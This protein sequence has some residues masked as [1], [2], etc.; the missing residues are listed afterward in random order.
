M[1]TLIFIVM[2]FALQIFY[3]LVGRRSASKVESNEEYFLAG[4]SV[5]FFPLMMTF[6]AT[7]VGGGMM[8]GSTEEAYKWGWSVVFYPLGAALGLIALG[9]GLGRKLSQFNVSTIAEILEVV[10]KSSF[11]KRFASVLSMASLFLILMAQMVASAHFLNSMGFTSTP[12]YLLFWV[13]VILY[14]A[15]GGLWTVIATDLV[16]A[17][18]FSCVILFCGALVWFNYSIPPF[19][20]DQIGLGSSKVTGWF[21]MPLFFNLVEQ[22]LGQRCFAGGS[23]KIVSKATLVAGLCM[24]VICV[25][26]VYFGVLAKSMGIAIPAGSSVL[27]GIVSTLTNP[28]VTSLMGCAVI[29]A[30]ISTVT[31]LINAISSNMLNDFVKIKNVNLMRIFTFLVASAAMLLAL[32]FNNIV[33]LVIFGYEL[34]VCCLLVPI[35]IALFKR[36]GNFYSALFAVVFGLIGFALFRI[37]PVSL[38]KEI[39]AI[40]LSLGGFVIG[41]PFERFQKVSSIQKKETI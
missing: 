4:K 6:L 2:L 24:V 19:D 40:L 26:P 36:N 21:L 1:D 23:G 11:L 12:L 30:I 22:D 41:I 27:I 14:T 13:I 8:L 17:V 25:V 31:S 39:G 5:P 7:K 28:W 10:Y 29:A 34:L 35:V 38:P 18:V 33:D 3:Y 37:Y 15:R 16:Q 9:C 20:F 32:L